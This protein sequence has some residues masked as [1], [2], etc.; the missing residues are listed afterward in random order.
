MPQI[1]Y[2]DDALDIINEEIKRY[3]QSFVR[4]CE[5]AARD[6]NDNV[7]SKDIVMIVSCFET[8]RQAGLLEYFCEKIK[9][10]ENEI[11]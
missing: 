1:L 7:V 11:L 8:I 10:Y 5:Q 2:D 4:L 6:H 9:E 3:K